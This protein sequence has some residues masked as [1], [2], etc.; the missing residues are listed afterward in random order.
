MSGRNINPPP[1]RDWSL[2]VGADGRAVAAHKK[3]KYW[4]RED[5]SSWGIYSGVGSN[6]LI[7]MAS[8]ARAI[9][10]IEGAVRGANAG[11]PQ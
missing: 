1:G 5:G 3:S 8:L 4:T 9:L 7:G 11:R 10:F 6:R 2:S